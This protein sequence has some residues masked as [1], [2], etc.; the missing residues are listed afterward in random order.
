MRINVVI[1]ARI[2][3]NIKNELHLV[4]TSSHSEIF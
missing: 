1:R 4:R 2:D 3:E